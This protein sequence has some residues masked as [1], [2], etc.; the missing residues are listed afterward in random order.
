M[1][2]VLPAS[3]QP[4]DGFAAWHERPPNS[5][6]ASVGRGISATPSTPSAR[7]P[8]ASRWNTASPTCH[9]SPPH[10]GSAASRCRASSLWQ[11]GSQTKTSSS[12]T[13]AAIARR[14]LAGAVDQDSPLLFPMPPVAQPHGV[15][16]SR[17]LQTRNH[18]DI[19]QQNR[20]RFRNARPPP[21]GNRRPSLARIVNGCATIVSL[22]SERFEH[23]L[24]SDSASYPGV[25][26]VNSMNRGRPAV[27]SAQRSSS[28]GKCFDSR[29]TSPR[30]P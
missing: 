23:H 2:C 26:H 8:N 1:Q 6:L 29:H 12:F 10:C 16:H 4:A 25:W 11:S 21:L 7:W 18:V 20:L 17:I 19:W 14:E 5:S 13:P 22:A 15:F 30:G 28:R 9:T 24:P 27:N 3:G